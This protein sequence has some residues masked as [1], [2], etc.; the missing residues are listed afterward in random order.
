MV[1]DVLDYG[2]T[3]P[4]VA[5]IVETDGGRETKCLTRDH[6][7][8]VDWGPLP[9]FDG[10]T[11]YGVACTWAR[12]TFNGYRRVQEADVRLNDDSNE[13]WFFTTDQQP[14][15]CLDPFFPGGAQVDL[16]GLMTHERGHNFGLGHVH[17][18]VHPNMTMSSGVDAQCNT[19][20][21]TLGKGDILGL[22]YI[23][24]Q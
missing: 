4:D 8:V 2:R 6:H 5:N 22:D 14:L 24:T 19:T 23:Y 12:E 9:R 3:T 16:E 15:D 20:V 7:S 18:N 1:H 10:V 11:T 13:V 17:E 21:R